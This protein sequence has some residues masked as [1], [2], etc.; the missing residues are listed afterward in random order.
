MGIVPLTNLELGL[1]PEFGDEAP[2]W[3]YALAESE[4]REGGTRL[5]D[6]AGRITAEVILTELAIDKD[7]Y[8]NAKFPGFFPMVP[9]EGAFGM[10]DFMQFA[11]VA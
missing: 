8:L 9:H 5:G 11:G 10:G 3:Y 7:S 2:L 4:I 1:G 6:V